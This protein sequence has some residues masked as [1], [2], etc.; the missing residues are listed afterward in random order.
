M[1]HWRIVAGHWDPNDTDETKSVMLGDWIRHNY[2][3]IGYPKKHVQYKTFEEKVQINDKIVVTTSGHVWALGTV[4]S[5]LYHKEVSAKSY[6]Y[7]HRRD[8]I[9]S[10]VTKVPFKGF[11]KT[12][13]NKLGLLRGINP[14]TPED[15]ETLLMFV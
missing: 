9:W 13:K 12:L 3:S 6:L 1:K 7:P 11:P 14:L 5:D 4:T 10:T 15:W 8:V 2:V